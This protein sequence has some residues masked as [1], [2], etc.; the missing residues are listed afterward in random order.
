[1]QQLALLFW[2]ICL[3]QK[4]PQDVPSAGILLSILLLLSVILDMFSFRLTSPETDIFSNLLVIIIYSG[5]V[6]ASTAILL[7]L[8]GYKQRTLQTVNALFGTGLVI[9]VCSF[10]V[11]ALLYGRYDEPGSLGMVLVLMQLW[12]LLVMAHIL[13]H[14]LSVSFILGGML[15]FAYM[16]MGFQIMTLFSDR[17][18]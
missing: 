11:L 3:L 4:G 14:A 16:M 9:A 7:Q 18:S 5:L 15:S 13:R 17:V 1:M 12:H 10:P 6:L 2:R 8:L